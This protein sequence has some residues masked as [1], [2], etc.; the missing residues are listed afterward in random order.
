MNGREAAVTT[1]DPI[2]AA[3]AVFTDERFFYEYAVA[4]RPGASAS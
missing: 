1:D 3:P 2:D 4:A